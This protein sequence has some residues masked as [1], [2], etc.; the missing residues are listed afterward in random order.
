MAIDLLKN[1]PQ[2]VSINLPAKEPHVFGTG[3]EN[4]YNAYK[5]SFL[6]STETTRIETPTQTI[7]EWAQNPNSN[8]TNFFSSTLYLKLVQS[9]VSQQ[10]AWTYSRTYYAIISSS[11]EQ[12]SNQGSSL[13]FEQTFDDTQP[14][15]LA[16]TTLSFQ[17]GLVY[18]PSIDAFT[19][20]L[21]PASHNDTMNEVIRGVY[22]FY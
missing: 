22:Y 11:P 17:S 18:D 6:I 21:Y 5:G 16:P 4:I 13:N 10:E 20:S 7:F 8:R 12:G 9:S 1:T 15:Q 3:G 14:N 19:F 2:G